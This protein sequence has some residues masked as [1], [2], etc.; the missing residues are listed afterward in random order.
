MT[1]QDAFDRDAQ[2]LRD[3]VV[4]SAIKLREHCDSVVI[5]CTMAEGSDSQMIFDRRGNVYAVMGSIERYSEIHSEHRHR[6]DL[7]D[8]E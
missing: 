1:D 4:Q 7:E 6:D 2:A 3:M 5:I 8:E